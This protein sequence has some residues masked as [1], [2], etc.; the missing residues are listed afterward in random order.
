MFQTNPFFLILTVSKYRFLENYFSMEF[1]RLNQLAQQTQRHW[2]GQN[3]V[4]V[5]NM[6]G[7]TV[8]SQPFSSSGRCFPKFS[9]FM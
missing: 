2:T 5:L 7:Q 9:D 4:K 8:F 1:S 6:F 3:V